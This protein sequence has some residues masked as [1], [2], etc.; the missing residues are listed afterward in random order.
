[1]RSESDIA[2]LYFYDNNG[3]RI[4]MTTDSDS[5]SYAIDGDPLTYYSAKREDPSGV[6]DA[7]KP[8]TLDHISYIRRGDG[9]AIVPE[10]TYRVS[11]WNG[12]GWIVHCEVEA[13]D[14]E[15]QIEDI[16]ADKLYYVE[17]LSRGVQNRIFLC[18][19][20]GLIWK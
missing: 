17:G 11:W 8:V 6:F 15:L 1:M 14:I 5:L 20:N 2:E 12:K 18:G 3:D 4:K 9:N 7:G 10:D 19:S 13:K 16:P